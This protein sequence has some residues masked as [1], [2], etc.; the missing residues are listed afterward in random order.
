MTGVPAK[1]QVKPSPVSL[2]ADGRSVAQVDVR[3]LDE[4][5]IPVVQPAYVT[6]RAQGAEPVG[7]DADAS[8]VGMQF[9]SSTS[10]ELTVALLPGREVGPGVLELK[11]GELTDTVPLQL[12]PEVRGL[13]VAGSGL[14]G[15]GASPDAY[16][17]ITARGPAQILT[18]WG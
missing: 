2:V 5:G 12:L 4:W 8:S 1:F 17:A 18:Q 6:V 11:S 13:T 10:G 3:V 16:G 9:L 7:R 14:V 15:V